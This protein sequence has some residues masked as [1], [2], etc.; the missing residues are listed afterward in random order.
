[1]IDEALALEIAEGAMVAD[2]V[3]SRPCVF[4]TETAGTRRR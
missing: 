1:V 4:L 3:E 2:M